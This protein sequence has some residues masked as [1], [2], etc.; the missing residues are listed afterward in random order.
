MALS[1]FPWCRETVCGKTART[2]RE[3]FFERL[4]EKCAM[5]IHLCKHCYETVP[6]LFERSDADLADSGVTV[7]VIRRTA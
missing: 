7:R 2:E 6:S 1:G 3:A 5:A 4:E